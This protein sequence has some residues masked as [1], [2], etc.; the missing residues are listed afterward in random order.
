MLA[1]A[2]GIEVKAGEPTGEL[3]GR[4]IERAEELTGT[5]AA[6]EARANAIDG[7]LRHWVGKKKG[8]QASGKARKPRRVYETVKGRV[9]VKAGEQV[10]P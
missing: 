7:S 3:M 10:T 2:L 4:C 1:Q 5:D 6:V 9:R 8:E